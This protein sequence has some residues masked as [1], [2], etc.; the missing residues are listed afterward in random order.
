MARS[1]SAAQ[2]QV[3]WL[4]LGLIIPGAVQAQSSSDLGRMSLQE[5]MT[6]EVTTASRS[7]VAATLV[8]AAV[9]VITGEAIERSGASSLAEVLRLAPGVQVARVDAGKWSIGVRGFADRLA[10]SM[11]VLIDGRVVYSPL[12]AGTYWEVQDV[13]LED[14]ERVEVIRGPGG[15]LW[16]S[17][18]VN[19][20]IS[21]VTK[22]SRATQGLLATASAGSEERVQVGLRYGTALGS[23]GHVRGYAKGFDVRAQH[24]TDSLEYDGWR[25]VQTGFRLDGLIGQR[26]DLTVQGDAYAARLGEFV[27]ETS[28]LPPFATTLTR[29]LPLSGGNVLARLSRTSRSGSSVQLQTFF[30]VT[31]RDEYPVSETR[32]T[33]DADLVVRQYPG[34]RNE[35]LWGA[36]YRLTSADISTAATSSLP[37]GS[38]ILLSGFVQDEV[39]LAGGRVLLTAG[40]KLEHNRY[41]GLE[42]QPSGR[43]V[44]QVTP[45][46][47]L[48]G[49]VTRAV[50]RPSRVE[51]QYATMSVLSP[52]VPAFVR[53]EPN[54]DFASERV[55]ANEF[56][57]RARPLEQMYVTVAAFYNRWNDLLST[58]LIRD[59]FR[60]SPPSEPGR[61]V[62]PVAFRNGLDGDSYGLET[63]LELRPVPGWRLAGHHAF[64]RV[65]MTPKPGSTDLTQE[66][67]YEGGSPRHQFRLENSVD[68][69]NAFTVDWHLRYVGELPDVEVPAYTTSDLRLAWRVAAGLELEVVGR[70]L[71]SPHHAEWQGENGGSDVE[72][73]RSVYVGAVLRR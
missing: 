39:S 46:N 63:S 30:D 68:V 16:G 44:W 20:I 47:T 66:A 18:A 73:E 15:T 42:V 45:S 36:G 71:H 4:V 57:Y 6:L 55:L 33:F 65:L 70:N 41:S 54:P 53:L 67:R 31:D 23:F 24:P 21:I 3:T 52:S 38:E 64:L 49:S 58:E 56:G 27:R 2:V 7:P 60:E 48:W 13:L 29:D 22:S 35:L 50:R 28:L 10:R 25:V 8:P 9:F 59:P 12:F 40:V 26:T 19:G 51:R 62:F 69:A 17:N 1:I 5:L 32:Q 72:I 43:F 11:L 34:S 14:I 37:S 61:L